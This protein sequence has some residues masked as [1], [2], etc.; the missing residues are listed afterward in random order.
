MSSHNSSSVVNDPR[1]PS[2]A[3]PYVA[4]VVSPEN[5]PI[6]YSGFLAIIFG[7]AGVMFRYKLSSWLSIIFCAHSLANMRNL[8]T[9]LKQISTAIMARLVR[10]LGMKWTYLIPGKFLSW[11]LGCHA[12]VW[13]NRE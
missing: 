11:H 4:P 3:K 13:F 5:L 12:D 6:D 9:D 8:E 1:L 7:V 2:S 10:V